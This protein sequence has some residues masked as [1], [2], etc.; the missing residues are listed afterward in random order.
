MASS[1]KK[2]EGNME[3]THPD[4]WPA[5]SGADYQI[6]P[7]AFITT[8]PETAAQT[9]SGWVYQWVVARFLVVPSGHIVATIKWV[10]RYHTK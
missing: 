10:P 9:P 5:P 1:D 4:G 7:S 2:Y 3:R 8:F 6:T